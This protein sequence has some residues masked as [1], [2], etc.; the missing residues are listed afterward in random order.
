MSKFNKTKIAAQPDAVTYEGGAAFTKT[1]EQDWLNNL[2][3]NTL[4]NRFYESADEQ[5]ERYIDL[6]EKMLEK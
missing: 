5:L 2:F 6:T 3:S 1:L 4:E